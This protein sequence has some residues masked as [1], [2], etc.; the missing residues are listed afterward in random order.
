MLITSVYSGAETILC[1]GTWLEVDVGEKVNAA[2][3]TL[4]NDIKFNSKN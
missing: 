2:K 1:L 3:L 4:P